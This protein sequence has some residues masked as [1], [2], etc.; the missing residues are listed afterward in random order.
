MIIFNFV[1]NLYQRG[2]IHKVT[3]FNKQYGHSLHLTS[4]NLDKDEFFLTE[5]LFLRDGVKYSWPSTK[6]E[7]HGK[8]VF[9]DSL[10]TYVRSAHSFKVESLL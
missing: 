3:F 10:F 7:F 6:K 9:C 1:V 5:L 2:N 4:F 8:P